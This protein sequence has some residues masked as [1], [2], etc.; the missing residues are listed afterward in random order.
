MHVLFLAY[1]YYE[2]AAFNVGGILKVPHDLQ[3][4]FQFVWD[5]RFITRT[6]KNKLV[7]VTAEEFMKCLRPYLS[8][9][10]WKRA[11][12]KVKKHAQSGIFDNN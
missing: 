5:L 6:E 12:R 2:S 7:N 8:D 1:E 10:R 4:F 9:F 3:G 11:I